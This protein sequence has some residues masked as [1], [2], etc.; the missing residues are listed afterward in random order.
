[1]PAV[2]ATE[3]WSLRSY[4]KGKAA[5][6]AWTV[7]FATTATDAMNAPNVAHV[8]ER[9]PEDPQLSIPQGGVEAESPG[10]NFWIVKASYV[11]GSFDGNNDNTLKRPRYRWEQGNISEAVDVD[12]E[13]RPL[14]NSTGDPFGGVYGDDA[15]F[16][17]TVTRW[18]PRYDLAKAATYQN[19]CNLDN[20]NPLG[21]G[22]LEPGQM[23]CLAII[24]TED[25]DASEISIKIAYRFEIRKGRTKDADNK[26]DAFKH[27]LIDEGRRSYYQA[28]SGLKIGEIVYQDGR[29]PSG[30]VLLNGSGQ[31]LKPGYKVKG[32]DGSLNDPVDGVTLDPSLLEKTGDAVFLKNPK[33]K[34]LSFAALGLF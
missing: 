27:R 20:I 4:A 14:V 26:W 32:V 17:L 28:D 16:Y 25:Y 24:P 10:F 5:T 30:P 15:V 22:A 11:L 18:E 29:E 23:K 9:F 8:G 34:F 3:M 33:T 13:A 6:R 31:P 1:M 19:A 12:A 21:V 2:E 7:V